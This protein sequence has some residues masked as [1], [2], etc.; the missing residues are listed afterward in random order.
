MQEEIWK[1]IEGY[2]DLYQV[3]NLGRVRRLKFINKTTNKYQERIVAITDNGEGYKI[4]SLCKNGKRKNYYI[5]RLIATYF[6]PNKENKLEINHIDGNKNNNNINNLEWCTRSENLIHAYNHKLRTAPMSMLGKCGKL[7][8]ISIPV[9]MYDLNNHFIKEFESANI[10]SKE[11]NI[12]YASIKKCRCGKQKT[13]G[14]YIW[15]Y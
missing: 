14:G 13:A 3:S 1:D 7:D 8:G 12:C 9:K 2:E 6:I 4:V 10:A 5:H 15:K 11:T